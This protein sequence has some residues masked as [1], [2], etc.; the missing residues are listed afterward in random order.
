MARH[1]GELLQEALELE[2][3]ARAALA[4]CLLE[5]LEPE[6]DE[7]V[8]SAWRVEI[9]RRLSEIEA[10]TALLVPWAEARRQIQEA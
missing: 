1:P 4:S 9:Q 3:E 10:G 2:P 5:S 6:T 7:D 8:E